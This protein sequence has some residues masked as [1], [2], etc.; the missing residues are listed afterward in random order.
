MIIYLDT[1]AVVP[2][3]IEEPSTSSCRQVWEAA[4]DAVTSRLTYVETA[5]ALAQATRLGR[6]TPAQHRASLD[7]LKALWAQCEVLDLDQALAVTAANLAHDH[8]LRGYD[9]V[10]C[11][12]GVRLRDDDLVAVSGDHTLLTAWSVLGVATL[13]VNA[14]P[15]PS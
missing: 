9:A 11:A 14:A 13:D 10:H 2:M 15:D 7:L 1:S 6:L 8:G 12:A 5:A 4:D 3:L